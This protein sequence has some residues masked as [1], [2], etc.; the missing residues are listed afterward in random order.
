MSSDAHTRVAVVV[1]G[2]LGRSPRMLYHAR[3]LGDTGAEVDL[4]GYVTHAL[5]SAVATH[6]RV[7]VHRLWA[8]ASGAGAR[9]PRPA[10]LVYAL[11]RGLRQTLEL[12]WTLL[13]R[14]PRPA[15]VLVQNP[16]A[17]PT[18]AVAL[19]VCRVRGA[20]LIIDWHNLGHAMLAL[21]LGADHPLV[22]LA[23]AY[24]RACGR[25]A[26][27]HLCVSRALGAALEERWAIAGATVLYDRPADVFV[28]T[29]ADARAALL[30]RLGHGL[31]TCLAAPDG[32]RAALIVSPSSWT[33]DE[34]VDLLLGALAA[35]DRRLL[36][37]AGASGFGALRVVVALTGDGPLRPR[38]QRRIDTL[39]LSAVLIR[40]LWLEAADY[41]RLV[42]AADL[43]L[44]VHRSASGLDLPMKIADMFG[45]GVPVCAL[46][47]APCLRE[48]IRDGETGVL[49]SDAAE[50]AVQLERLLGAFPVR[51][52]E[53]DRLR[54]NVAAHE[55]VRWADAWEEAARPMLAPSE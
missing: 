30:R 47:Y 14:V 44:S 55:R 35:L 17:I 46:G 24:E 9:L 39:G 42:G 22:G 5:P 38:Y 53:L 48:Q 36:A 23:T 3:S 18:L 7:H 20:R 8:P 16:P 31:E 43:G 1:L 41:P 54:A 26:D 33:A 50:L 4:V 52:T 21:T 37:A 2:D 12:C 19:A 6:P 13:A 49:F 51:T 25:L 27:G 29:P 15:V 10:F 28:S 45:A 32:N 11:W 40:T 34:D